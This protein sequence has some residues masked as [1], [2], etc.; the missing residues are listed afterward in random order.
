MSSRGDG[1]GY[2]ITRTDMEASRLVFVSLRNSLPRRKVAVPVPDGYT[3]A[4]FI[5]QVKVKLKIDGVAAIYLASSGEQISSLEGLE[6]IDELHVEEG[7]PQASTPNGLVRSAIP[8]EASLR[9]GGE[10]SSSEIQYAGM[11]QSS[12]IHRQQST[13]G[14]N[15]KVSIEGDEDG[16]EK[17]VRRSNFVKRMAQRIFPDAFTPS[18]P[19]TS[20]ASGGADEKDGSRGR[21]LKRR[22]QKGRV[23]QSTIFLIMGMIGSAATMFFLYW[24]L[25]PST[26]Q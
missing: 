6:D 18:L 3:W 5:D 19:V 9:T 22:R 8:S 7:A 20:R 17:Y 1:R 23:S 10:V 26:V 25:F 4:Q 14:R 11:A 16:E 24:R 13:E 15:H 12:K 2:G 21:G